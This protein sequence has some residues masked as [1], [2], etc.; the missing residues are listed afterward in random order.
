MRKIKVE[1]NAG[2][3]EGLCVITPQIYGDSRG[4]FAETYNEHDMKEAGFDFVFVQDNQSFSVKGVLRGMHYQNEHSQ[5]KII[6][7]IRGEVFDVVIDL[8]K[9]SGTFGKWHGELLSSENNRQLIVPRGFAHGFLVLSSH[10]DIGYKC[11]DFYHP[12]DEAGIAWNDPEIGIEWPGIVGTYTG[13][14]SAEGY[15]LEDGTPI[16]ISEKD[17]KLP[18]LSSNYYDC[19]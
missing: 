13:T 3:I 6:R 12:E 16:C 1:Y 11:D 14:A 4:W 9:D 18:Q 8:R 17:Q 2:G 5:T 7:V 10:A 15:T 19:R